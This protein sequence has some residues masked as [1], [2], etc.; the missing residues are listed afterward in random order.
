MGGQRRYADSIDRSE[1]QKFRERYPISVPLEVWKNAP[2]TR[3]DGPVPV[4]CWVF[5]VTRLP[6]RVPGFA[7]WWTDRVVQVTFG[8]GLSVV[9]WR[10]AVTH[11]QA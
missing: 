9:V 3:P 7:V 5:W 1:A 8:D 10:N 11:R 2:Q 4:W 6:E